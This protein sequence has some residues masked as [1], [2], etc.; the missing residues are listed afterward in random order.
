MMAVMKALRTLEEGASSASS[1]PALRHLRIRAKRIRDA[2][3]DKA[4]TA[5][6]SRER[7]Q[8]EDM[9]SYADAIVLKIDHQLNQLVVER[10]DANIH[11]VMAQAIAPF[12]RPVPQA[13]SYETLSAV[14]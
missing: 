9:A 3:R 8:L 4:A 1:T 12:L 10:V 13:R 7:A 14:E 5:L 2:L 11:P 6:A